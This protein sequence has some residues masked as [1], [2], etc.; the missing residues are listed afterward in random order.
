[1]KGLTVPVLMLLMSPAW[2]Q[3]VFENQSDVGSDIPPG[4]ASFNAAT[5]TNTLTAAGANTW[6]HVDNFHYL[7]KKS[8][9][10][11]SLTEEVSFQAISYDHNPVPHRKGI[12]LFR[13][14]LD[15]GGVY[16]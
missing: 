7:R 1:M 6:Y 3:G 8:A 16:V 13:Q 14:T 12:L 5:N 15:A 2:G 11:M 4:T 10:V 9:G